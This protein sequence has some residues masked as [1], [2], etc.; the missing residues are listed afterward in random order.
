MLVGIRGEVCDTGNGVVSDG[1]AQFFLGD[2][3]VRDGLDYIGSGNEH[4][5]GVL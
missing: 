4:I 2:F 5:R 3:F 1:A